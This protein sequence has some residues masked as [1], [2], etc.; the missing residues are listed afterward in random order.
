MCL[1]I[2]EERLPV[3]VESDIHALSESLNKNHGKVLAN[4]L[5]SA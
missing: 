2:Q 5:C 3:A 1:G 4:S